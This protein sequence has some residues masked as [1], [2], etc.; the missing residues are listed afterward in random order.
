MPNGILSSGRVDF[1]AAFRGR[2]AAVVVVF[3]RRMA[4]R[5]KRQNGRKQETG[6]WR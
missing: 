4:F 6:I 1:L 3:G 5:R 2:F